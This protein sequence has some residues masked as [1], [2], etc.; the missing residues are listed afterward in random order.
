M[1]SLVSG[2]SPQQEALESL[3]KGWVLPKATEDPD[4]GQ[5]VVRL[6][7]WNHPLAAL[8]RVSVWSQEEEPEA[9][10]GV[11]RGAGAIYTG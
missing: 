10:E 2:S 6:A 7:F 9:G 3:E 5:G 8:W 11:H 4:A 1:P